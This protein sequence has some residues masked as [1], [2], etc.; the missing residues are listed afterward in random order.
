[1]KQS[2]K[3]PVATEVIKAHFPQLWGYVHQTHMHTFLPRC[4]CVYSFVH[5]CMH[6][7][8]SAKR[9]LLPPS[10]PRL[11]H[12]STP[13]TCKKFCLYLYILFLFYFFFCIFSAA[14]RWYFSFVFVL[15][16]FCTQNGGFCACFAVPSRCVRMYVVFLL[17]FSQHL[18]R[19]ACR[20]R[21]LC[22]WGRRHAGSVV[23]AIQKLLH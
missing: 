18:F 16:Q 2:T 8:K 15:F 12:S 23:E 3:I 7:Q 17:S 1:M 6:T 14:I 10:S 4:I 20:L 9:V 13:F 11:P 19:F 21:A 5:V 22:C